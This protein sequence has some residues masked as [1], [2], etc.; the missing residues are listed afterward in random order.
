[1]VSEKVRRATVRR[2]VCGND[3]TAN[4]GREILS[5]RRY[6]IGRTDRSTVDRTSTNGRLEFRDF[7]PPGG[8]KLRTAA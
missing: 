4:P 6:D 8:D 1:M 2:G 3:I 5:N 7:F